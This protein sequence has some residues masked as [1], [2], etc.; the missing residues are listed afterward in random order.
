MALVTLVT[1]VYEVTP[2]QVKQGSIGF[3]GNVYSNASLGFRYTPP[4][5][6]RDRTEPFRLQIQERAK[7]TGT[8]NTLNAVLAMSSGP[9]DEDQTW[10][11]LTIETYPRNAVSEPDDAKAAAKMS[12]WVANSKDASALPRTVVIS[13]QSFSVSLFGS[14][15]GTVRKGAVV[16]TTVRKGQLLSFAF[17][18]NS[19]DQLKT[20]TE[21]IK[22]LQFF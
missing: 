19:P 20:L 16:W 18:A 3:L 2:A 9:D 8:A 22:S 7:V 4:G 13:G 21:S 10:H 15:E 5:G 11:S 12:A 1:M 6:M 17:A 14:Q